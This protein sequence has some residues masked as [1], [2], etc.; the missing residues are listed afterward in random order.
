MQN[1]QNN[2]IR[3][4]FRLASI[5][6]FPALLLV[7]GC[8]DG[9]GKSNLESGLSKLSKGDYNGAAKRL[10]IS[11]RQFPDN[12]TAWCNLGIVQLKL[13]LT[14]D[15]ALSFKKAIDLDP[16]NQAPLEFL[17]QALIRMGKLD[18][19]RAALTKA[20]DF[21]PNS[22]RISAAIGVV[23]FH[24][25][26]NEMA[27]TYWKQALNIDPNYAPA[28]YNLACL[29]RD[30][31]GNK[32]EANRYFQQYLE[33]AGNDEHA[34]VAKA[35]MEGKTLTMQPPPG[36]PMPP[37]IAEPAKSKPMDP[38]VV[39][40]RKAIERQNYDEALDLLKQAMKKDPTDSDAL[41]ELAVLYD[42]HLQLPD[43]AAQSYQKFRTL[44]PAD[45]R[46]GAKAEAPKRSIG[47]V[48]APLPLQPPPRQ[49][50]AR[51]AQEALTSGVRLYNLKDW[52]GAIAYY[53]R[54]LEFDNGSADILYNLGLA[55]KAK[56]DLQTA[57]DRFSDALKANSSMV[58]AGY[59][60]A[61]VFREMKDTESAVAQL[62][63]VVKAQPTYADAQCLMGFLYL[64]KGRPD[65]A[66]K[67]FE[68]Y[69][70]LDPDGESAKQVKEWL[71]KN[72]R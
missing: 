71:N 45:P 13:G 69:L 6:I 15:A 20:G 63:K 55:Y 33:I 40:A 48:A 5:A 14:E 29:Y 31:Y 36:P 26:Q 43:K 46:A 34:K 30:R 16:S 62:N 28:I 17:A 47:P 52:D 22:P 8:G 11:V 61:V 18:D 41:W 9:S 72:R 7:T 44:F 4:S 37:Q 39:S 56:G 19:A 42:T 53:K 49:V 12:A 25:G 1:H 58:K 54:A 70:Q 66:R 2:R 67:R 10:E 35:A 68:R 65:L 21:S 27:D 24:A 51:S 38:L 64:D 59:M 23:E 3:K 57:R 50:D 60:L 32:E